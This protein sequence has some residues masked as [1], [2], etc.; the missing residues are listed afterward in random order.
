MT[1]RKCNKPMRWAT[2]K[3]ERENGNHAT[4]FTWTCRCGNR[5]RTKVEE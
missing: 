5:A 3:F 1:C 2:T 4:H